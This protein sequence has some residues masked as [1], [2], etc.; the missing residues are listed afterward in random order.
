LPFAVVVATGGSSSESSVSSSLSALAAATFA[1]ASTELGTGAACFDAATGALTSSSPLSS[2]ELVSELSAG[3]AGALEAGLTVLAPLAAT[4]L[5]FP[6]AFCNTIHTCD[7]SE[8]H[9]QLAHMYLGLLWLLLFS[10]G[11]LLC[12]SRGFRVFLDGNKL[13]GCKQVALKHLQQHTLAFF[14]S[15]LA[16]AIAD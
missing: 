10:L 16:L 4:S 14:S 1:C 2:E 8:H 12:F 7:M 6:I 11:S 15:L 9:K 5:G 13:M 3:G